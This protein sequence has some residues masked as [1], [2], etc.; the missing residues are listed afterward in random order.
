MV[1]WLI[2]GMSCYVNLT[3]KIYVVILHGSVAG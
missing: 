1:C 2:R 3:K